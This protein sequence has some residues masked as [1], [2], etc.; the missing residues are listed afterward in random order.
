MSQMDRE[1]FERE[2]LKVVGRKITG[3]VQT[4]DDGYGQLFGFLLDDR[5]SLW[6][7]TDAEG[8][9]PGWITHDPPPPKEG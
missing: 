3:L 6:I 5:S 7:A 1:W 8:N 4:P 2:A 9:G